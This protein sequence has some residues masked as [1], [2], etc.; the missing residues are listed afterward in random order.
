MTPTLPNNV[1]NIQFNIFEKYDDTQ[2]EHWQRGRSGRMLTADKGGQRTKK[3]DIRSSI[4]ET[5]MPNCVCG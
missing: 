5:K 4:S 2:F 3:D 1:S